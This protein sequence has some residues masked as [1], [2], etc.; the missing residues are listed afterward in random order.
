MVAVSLL[1]T[2]P[3]ALLGV[4]MPDIE[5]GALRPSATNACEKRKDRMT[6]WLE[7]NMKATMPEMNTS[8]YVHDEHE[9]HNGIGEPTKLPQA[10]RPTVHAFSHPPAQPSAHPPVRPSDPPFVRPSDRSSARP[11]ARPRAPAHQRAPALPPARLPV[12][13]SVPPFF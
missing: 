6:E 3:Y 8:R 13:P 10:V 5:N 4:A 11:L 2:C 7:E 9:T 12:R 1:T